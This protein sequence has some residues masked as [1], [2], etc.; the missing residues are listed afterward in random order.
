MRGIS[1]PVES[2]HTTNKCQFNHITDWWKNLG[3][4]PLLFTR[5]SSVLCEST[6]QLIGNLNIHLTYGVGTFWNVHVSF[7]GHVLAIFVCMRVW[8][9]ACVCC[10]NMHVCICVSAFQCL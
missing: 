6:V 1:K 8:Q 2:S 7:S 9:C 3:H 5:G 4:S 10:M